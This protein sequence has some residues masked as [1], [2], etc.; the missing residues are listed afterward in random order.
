MKILLVQEAG[1]NPD[2]VEYKEAQNFKRA[3]ARLG[4]DTTV[5]WGRGY[6][7]TQELPCG[8]DAIFILENYDD[9]WM[10]DFAEVKLPKLFWSVD[11]HKDINTHAAF[12]INNKI[13]RVLCAVY[14]DVNVFNR[15]G[16]NC[17]F[18]P[19]AYPV[20]LFD[21]Q[22]SKYYGQHKYKI[23]F[24]GNYGNRR[25][26][27]DSL[28]I[29]FPSF[30]K[31]IFVLGDA[32]VR[33][34]GNYGIHFNRNESYDINARTFET[35]GAGAMLLTNKTPGVQSLFRDGHECVFY[36]SI[37]DCIEKA[38]YY[39]DHEWQRATIASAGRKDVEQ[40]HTYDVRAKRVI[41]I[42]K[43]IV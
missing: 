17:E 16:L 19:N 27:I 24:C 35:M 40:R 22:L 10:P 2:N 8:C 25:E 23:G 37:E 39:I 42:L 15:F 34:V 21:A 1:K 5:V 11:S 9:G 30:R 4:V 31:D 6:N 38:K 20:D 43:E 29:E 36:D 7:N 32:M 33:T 28:S 14:D 41:D 3:F 12:C 26:W 18:F 13:D